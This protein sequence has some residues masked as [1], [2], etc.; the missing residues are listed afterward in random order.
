MR[1]SGVGPAGSNPEG[2]VDPLSG[3]PVATA[4]VAGLMHALEPAGGYL[5]IFGAG[6][7][8]A[9]GAYGLFAGL[10]FQRAAARATRARRVIRIATGG[11]SVLIGAGW[12]A[13]AV[14]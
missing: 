4:L 12:M 1:Q 5:L 6:T 3:F 10:L 9:M 13:G 11:A 2:G 8:A 7:V 14:G